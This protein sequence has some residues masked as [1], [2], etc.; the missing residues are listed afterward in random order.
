MLNNSQEGNSI[1]ATTIILEG[2]NLTNREE[3]IFFQN[4]SKLHYLFP[5]NSFVELTLHNDHGYI[6]FYGKLEIIT[7]EN[8]FKSEHSDLDI[9]SLFDR[10]KLDIESQSRDWYTN[11]PMNKF[12]EIYYSMMKNDSTWRM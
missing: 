11:W 12:G 2:V 9:Y 3:R 10:L 6:E 5:F 1:G 4:L 7:F 8:K